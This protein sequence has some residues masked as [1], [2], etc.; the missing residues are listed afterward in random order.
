MTPIRGYPWWTCVD[1]YEG[2]TLFQKTEGVLFLCS[3]PALLRLLSATNLHKAFYPMLKK[4]NLLIF[5]GN[6]MGLLFD[7][8]PLILSPML[9]K[10][11]GNL[12]EA[13]FVQQLHY[14]LE[15]KK[16][17]GKNYFDGRYW[18]Y[19]SYGE[20]LKQFPWMSISTL[21]RTINSLTEKGY[22]IRGDY[23]Q[24]KMDHTIWYSLDYDKIREIDEKSKKEKDEQA[25]LALK[26]VQRD[27]EIENLESLVAQEVSRIDQNDQIDVLKS[28]NRCDQNEQIDVL[29]TIRSM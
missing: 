12:N 14:W 24:K 8:H 19:N 3:V 26:T 13:V 16:Q 17:A 5:G 1:K 27:E 9:A 2:H 18:V 4:W 28:T 10:E 7:E 25:E 6:N 23:N 15:N 29:K 11:L 20:W 22:I 21:R